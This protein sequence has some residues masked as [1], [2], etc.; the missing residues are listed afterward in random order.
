MM[1]VLSGNAY[2]DTLLAKFESIYTDS[3]DHSSTMVSMSNH[4]PCESFF[5]CF[6]YLFDSFNVLQLVLNVEQGL[7]VLSE[8]LCFNRVTARIRQGF[9]V[10]PARFLFR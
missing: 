1:Y 8:W 3:G 10:G 9:E 6:S 7:P 4:F 2:D 5:K